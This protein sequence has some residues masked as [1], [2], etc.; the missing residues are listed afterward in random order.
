MRVSST[1]SNRHWFHI[2]TAIFGVALLAGCNDSSSGSSD[3]DGGEDSNGSDD[4]ASDISNADSVLLFEQV[5]GNTRDRVL[6]AVDI[7][8][9]NAQAEVDVVAQDNMFARDEG[10]FWPPGSLSLATPDDTNLP[11]GVLSGSYSGGTLENAAFRY[12]IFNSE[13]GEL[14]RV[15]TLNGETTAERFSSESDAEVVCA[16]FVATDQ[17]DIDNSRLVYQVANNTSCSDT[18]IRMARIG[19]DES[20][21]VVTLHDNVEADDSFQQK[22]YDL[23]SWLLNAD[24]SLA[25]VVTYDGS[26]L[27]T[28]DLDSEDT[29]TLSDSSNFFRHLGWLDG[30]NTLVF[31][32]DSFDLSGYTVGGNPETVGAERIPSLLQDDH[33]INV[34]NTLYVVDHVDGNS[35]TGRVYSLDDDLTLTELDT[36]WGSASATQGVTTANGFLAFT[37]RSNDDWHVRQVALDDGTASDIVNDINRAIFPIESPQAPGSDNSFWFLYTDLGEAGD[38]PVARGVE[39]TSGGGNM[40]IDNAQWAGQ[41]WSREVGSAGP[42][43]EYLVYQQEVSGDD[44]LFSVAADDPV[45]NTAINLGLNEELY[46]GMWVGGFGPRTLITA[47]EDTPNDNRPDTVYIDAATEGSAVRLTE[48]NSDERPVPFY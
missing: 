20:G 42:E 35:S 47:R 39:F 29:T 31:A 34:D 41:T 10:W 23:G 24:G 36:G 8:D 33:V 43:A 3:D 32:G 22:N 48:S 16:S 1:R 40:A 7:D 26:Q 14:Y 2:L 37:Y 4:T 15:D 18:E 44:Q 5:S 17:A 21:S 6:I 46:A 19:D 9:A 28:Y 45:N 27:Q 13:D 38:D 12:T 11:L 25:E 30:L